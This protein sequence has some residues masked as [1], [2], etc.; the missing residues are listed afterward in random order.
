[1]LIV[2]IIFGN[3]L[4][5]KDSLVINRYWEEAI[6]QLAFLLI[7]IRA[8]LSID[9]EMLKNSL[10]I[11]SM[12]GFG[13]TTVE[14]I[15]ITLATHFFFQVPIFIAIAFAF[16]LAATSPAITVPTMIR[17]QK[18]ERGTDKGIP[19]VILAGATI[20]NLYCIT[21]FYIVL[22]TVLTAS[23]NGQLSYTIPRVLVEVLLAGIF[24]L[25]AGLALRSLP[26]RDSGFLHFSRATMTIFMSLALFYGT[27]AIQCFIAGP[28]I[29]FLMCIVATMRWKYD[30]P[31][32]VRELKK[33]IFDGK[34]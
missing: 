7:L 11:C 27:R 17:L 25:L 1:M 29:V 32:R 8:S 30:N 14:V 22:A 13:S 15:V 12:L 31:K 20:D 16:I 24:G 2:G 28:V 34:F 3:V 26:Q 6:R 21:V 19:T 10:Y 18:E 33:Y 4:A 23:N 9:P 5:F